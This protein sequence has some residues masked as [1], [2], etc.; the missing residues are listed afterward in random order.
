LRKYH[1]YVTR[2]EADSLADLCC[3]R[4]GVDPV[5]LHHSALGFRDHLLGDD[6]DITHL[7]GHAK[8]SEALDH[9]VR[10]RCA[11]DDLREPG[12]GID[13]DRTQARGRRAAGARSG[14]PSSSSRRRVAVTRGSCMNATMSS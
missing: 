13:R 6:D 12:Y 9:E 8:P 2:I 11:P 14:T 5:E 7:E 1:L 10:Q 4:G 3:P